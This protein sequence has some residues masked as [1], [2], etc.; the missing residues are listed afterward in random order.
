MLTKNN[1]GQ[2]VQ[3][4]RSKIWGGT[5]TVSIFAVMMLYAFNENTFSTL[6]H[7]PNIMINQHYQYMSTEELQREVEV[8]SINGNLPF[9]MG[10]ELIHRWTKDKSKH[11]C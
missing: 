6:E 3:T 8:R 11:K 7:K 10:I 4:N 9:D 1:K 5:A 2:V